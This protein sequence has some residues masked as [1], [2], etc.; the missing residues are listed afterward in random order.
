[1]KDIVGVDDQDDFNDNF[2][3]FPPITNKKESHNI[4]IDDEEIIQAYSIFKTI[5]CFQIC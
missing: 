3:A 4:D 2:Y 1:M 5:N